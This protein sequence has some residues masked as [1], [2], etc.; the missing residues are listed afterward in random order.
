V[1]HAVRLESDT[2]SGVPFHKHPSCDTCRV[3]FAVAEVDSLRLGNR[4]RTY[5]GVMGLVAAFAA[6][7]IYVALSFPKT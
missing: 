3:V 2:L 4:E 7:A 6:L 5:F 1:L